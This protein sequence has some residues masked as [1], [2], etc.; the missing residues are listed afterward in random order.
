MNKCRIISMLLIIALIASLFSGCSSNISDDK[1]IEK[2]ETD[3]KK[4][5]DKNKGTNESK[6]ANDAKASDKKEEKAKPKK[7]T[8]DENFLFQVIEKAEKIKSYKSQTKTFIKSDSEQRAHEIDVDFKGKSSIPNDVEKCIIKSKDIKTNNSKLSKSEQEEIKASDN[9]SIVNEYDKDGNLSNSLLITRSHQEY[10]RKSA[11]EVV[12]KE[13]NNHDKLIKTTSSKGLSFTPN[14]YGQLGS[15][16]K[17]ASK[18]DVREKDGKIAFI[19]KEGGKLKKEELFKALEYDY[20]LHLSGDDTENIKT[21][22]LVEIDIESKNIET[23]FL[24]IKYKDN[25]EFLATTEYFDIK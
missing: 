7:Q 17:I 2:K 13:Y 8:I 11:N 1:E 25:M 12:L 19:F 4:S 10:T 5:D 6:D 22:F 23:V 9:K 14:Y 24:S 15:L 18:L 21:E 20:N 16:L 3:E